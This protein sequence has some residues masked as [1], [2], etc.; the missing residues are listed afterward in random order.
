M[1]DVAQ[2]DDFEKQFAEFSAA[3]EAPVTEP[4]EPTVAPAEETP[5]PVAETTPEPAPAKTAEPADDAAKLRADFEAL[6]KK[7]E[8]ATGSIAGYERHLQTERAERQRLEQALSVAMSKPATQEQQDVKD[9]SIAY[10]KENFPDLATAV[11]KIVESRIKGL[12]QRFAQFDSQVQQQMAPIRQ[13][14]E[15][16]V[17]ARE[18]SELGKAHPDYQEID[19]SQEFRQWL[20]SQPSFVQEASRSP[21]AQDVV[22]LLDFYKQD[23]GIAR[24]NSQADAKA[25]VQAR[26]QK[27]L[28]QAAGVS[29][30]SSAPP[31]VAAEDS[32]GSYESYF[33]FYSRKAEAKVA[34]RR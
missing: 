3:R 8:R 34:N 5:E 16:D 2:E 9:E 32:N 27:E 12:D 15:E 29:V 14:F 17:T 1:S 24:V 18:Y 30:R 10:L 22:R 25:E 33:D 20:A 23:T 7:F 26:R 11:D 6:Q 28:S 21:I 4:E 13:R 31:N 19:N